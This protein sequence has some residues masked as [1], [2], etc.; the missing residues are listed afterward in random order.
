MFEKLR[1]KSL[2]PSQERF[3][4]I[5]GRT[6]QI[7]GRLVLLDSVRIDGKVVGNIE[8]TKDNKVTVAIGSTGEVSG[9]ITAHRVMVAGKVE[10]NIYA[11]E[12]VEFHKDSVVQGD[13]SY[14]S[15]AVEHGAKL[16][17]LVIQNPTSSAASTSSSDAQNVIRRAQEGSA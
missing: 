5:I 12:R 7:Y 16:L 1:D 15:I 3:D 8:T 4:T 17:G 6:T 2:S 14:G 10:G 13:I 9:D 11:A